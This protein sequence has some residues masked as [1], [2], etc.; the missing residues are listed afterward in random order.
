M[1]ALLIGVVT[2]A[3]I[4]LAAT[5]LAARRGRAATV[6][7]GE[8]AYRASRST[9]PLP[10]RPG[11]ALRWSAGFGV[12]WALC[13]VFGFAPGGSALALM[14]MEGDPAAGYSLLAVCASGVLLSG[15]LVWVGIRALRDPSR[16]SR[17][18]PVAVWSAVHHVLVVLAFALLGDEEGV[19]LAGLAT[20]PCAAG[21]AHAL[22]MARL[23]WPPLEVNVFDAAA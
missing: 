15:A 6:E 17:H 13:T 16:V 9:A 22:F 19:M 5:H 4:A 12:F 14:V 23:A 21:L 3:G 1:L 18:R 8:G 20:V 10:E 7:A 2:F 11:E